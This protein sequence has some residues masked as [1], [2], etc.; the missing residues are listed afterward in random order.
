MLIRSV[1]P[2][3]YHSLQRGTYMVYLAREGVCCCRT[4]RA[5]HLEAFEYNLQRTC[6]ESSIVLPQHMKSINTTML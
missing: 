5:W 2:L 4:N 1:R 6:R 3:D